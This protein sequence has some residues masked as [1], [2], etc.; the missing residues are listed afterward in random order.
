MSLFSLGTAEE[1]EGQ[2]TD[3]LP[4]PIDGYLRSDR[5]VWK[6]EKDLGCKTIMAFPSVG[7]EGPAME[8]LGGDGTRG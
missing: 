8:V 5:V 4:P 7:A 6:P 2:G 3:S 1:S